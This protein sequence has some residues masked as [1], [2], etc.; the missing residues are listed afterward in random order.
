MIAS[1]AGSEADSKSWFSADQ[2]YRHGE[3]LV[4]RERKT[5]YFRSDK[6]SERGNTRD[7]PYFHR[8]TR[9]LRS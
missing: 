8:L 5:A 2:G 6:V 7:Q 4:S 3:S 1:C 9:R